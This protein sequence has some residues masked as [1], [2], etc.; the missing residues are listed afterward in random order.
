[1]CDYWL[2]LWLY[3]WINSSLQ[4]FE[5]LGWMRKAERGRKLTKAGVLFMDEFCGR[6][7]RS[8]MTTAYWRRRKKQ[9]RLKERIA[10]R[11]KY[12]AEKAGVT[13]GG[14]QDET[15]GGDEQYEQDDQGQYETAG[16][17]IVDEVVEEFEH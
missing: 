6:V 4:Q 1:M 7:R 5:K 13:A 14:D 17:D 10:R 15:A 9:E 3:L 2:T 16:G 11:K 12:E 8:P